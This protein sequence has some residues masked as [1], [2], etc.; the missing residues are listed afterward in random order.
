MPGVKDGEEDGVSSKLLN[1]WWEI[2]QGY[3]Y[4]I[5]SFLKEFLAEF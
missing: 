3:V 1:S 5:K 4:F 2:Y